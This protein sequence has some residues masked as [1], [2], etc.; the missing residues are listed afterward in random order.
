MKKPKYFQNIKILLHLLLVFDKP[1]HLLNER[2]EGT[3]SSSISDKDI[4]EM[5]K[6]EAG[7]KK[8]SLLWPH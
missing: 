4:I 8:L 7:D 2:T 6:M 1:C 3:G 5:I